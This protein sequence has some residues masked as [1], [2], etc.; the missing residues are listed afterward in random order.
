MAIVENSSYLAQPARRLIFGW[1]T[2]SIVVVLIF[3]GVAAWLPQANLLKPWIAL[4]PGLSLGGFLG[5]LFLYFR[6]YD[7]MLKSL[8][9][10]ALSASALAGIILQLGSMVRAKSTEFAPVDDAI[11]VSVMAVAFILSALFQKWSHR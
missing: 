8:L 3:A 6:H 5:L 10:K 7:E 9:L 11:V 4:L 2:W 1:V